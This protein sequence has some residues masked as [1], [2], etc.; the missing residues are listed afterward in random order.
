MLELKKLMA[1]ARKEINDED[2]IKLKKE[3]KVK[4]RQIKDAESI[5]KNLKRELEDCIQ[6]SQL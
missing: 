4:M 6:E 1:D 2:Q 3:I 5:V